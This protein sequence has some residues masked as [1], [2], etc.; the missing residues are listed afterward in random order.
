MLLL[1]VIQPRQQHIAPQVRRYRNGQ[2]ARDGGL[3]ARHGVL[4]RFQRRDRRARVLQVTLAVAGQAQAACRAH[5][6]SGLKRQFQA[7]E[8]S[9]GDGGRQ[10]QFPRG[11][12]KTAVVGR[13]HKDPQVLEPDHDCPIFKKLLK[14]SAMLAGFSSLQSG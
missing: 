4:A 11:G 10:I 8:R 9:T 13:R 5:E 7:L 6:Q 3:V 1:K 12:R 14:L 2:R